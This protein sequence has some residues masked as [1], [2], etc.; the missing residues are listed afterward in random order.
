MS[1]ESII[2]LELDGFKLKASTPSI[3][4]NRE[5]I[6]ADVLL[7]PQSD[8]QKLLARI[9]FASPVIAKTCHE[10]ANLQRT[11]IEKDKKRL[12]QEKRHRQVI[13]NPFIEINLRFKDLFMENKS[14]SIRSI[15]LVVQGIMDDI[16]SSMFSPPSNSFQQLHDI[17]DHLARISKIHKF[18]VRDCQ[19]VPCM[20][21]AMERLKDL[22]WR[23]Y[24]YLKK[25]LPSRYLENDWFPLIEE[26]EY[27]RIWN[28][29]LVFSNSPENDW[30]PLNHPAPTYINSYHKITQHSNTLLLSLPSE[31]LRL[32]FSFASDSTFAPRNSTSNDKRTLNQARS[33]L[34][35]NLSLTH[36][37][38]TDEAQKEHLAFAFINSEKSFEKLANHISK[39]KLTTSLRRLSLTS[40]TFTPKLLARLSKLVKNCINLYHFELDGNFDAR[41]LGYFSACKLKQII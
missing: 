34:L 4:Q 2:E 40:F 41:L 39:K 27:L 7:I 5:L 24:N 14:P 26:E 16:T 23:G 12:E 22:D 30:N 15:Q 38:W 13:A 1:Q 25:V 37:R 19:L 28:G 20:V 35:N 17:E 8:L 9:A 18:N 21:R 32:I 36:S 31:I 33:K 6:L 29:F 10:L 3:Y 11:A